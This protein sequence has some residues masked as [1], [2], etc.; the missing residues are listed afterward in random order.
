MKSLAWAA[1]TIAG[2]TFWAVITPFVVVLSVYLIN[3]LKP[4]I[5]QWWDAV[6]YFFG[7]VK[8]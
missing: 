4:L 3:L 1:W 7:L 2:V 8:P 5:F 6:F